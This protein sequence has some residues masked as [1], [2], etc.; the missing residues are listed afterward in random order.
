MQR[1]ILARLAG[2]NLPARA[3]IEFSTAGA[4]YTCT[5]GDARIYCIHGNEVDP[6]N[7]NRYEDL[8]KVARRLN[9]GQS[10]EQSEW[11]P[12]AGTKMVKDI[13]PGPDSSYPFYL[14]N[15][16]GTL[17]FGCHHA[18]DGLDLWRSDGTA[19]GTVLVD[20]VDVMR[21]WQVDA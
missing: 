15:V 20:E 11:T 19:S 5:V 9:A 10:L 6:W 16:N 17:F 1:L 4:G 8:A 2:D 21:C 12:N 7:Y 14:T 18:V 3:R 13:F